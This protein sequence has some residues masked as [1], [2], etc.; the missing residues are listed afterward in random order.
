[1]THRKAYTR[2][3]SNG[4]CWVPDPCAVVCGLIS[5]S[6]QQ[7]VD[8]L[9]HDV[10]EQREHHQ[11]CLLELKVVLNACCYTWHCILGGLESNKLHIAKAEQ[12]T[13]SHV[14]SCMQLSSTVLQR[15]HGLMH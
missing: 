14:L 10:R 4:S 3:T 2:E 5:S 11:G 1:M 13:Q 15:Q 6:R 12:H 7:S 9:P 8:P